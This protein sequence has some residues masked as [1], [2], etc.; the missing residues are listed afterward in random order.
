MAQIQRLNPPGMQ[1]PGNRY[2]H[3]IKAGN[4]VFIAGQTSV[5]ADGNIV[6]EGDITAQ[7]HQVYANLKTAVESVGGVVSD[8]VKTTTYLVDREHLPGIRS[9]RGE[10]FGTTLPTSTLLIV[11][12]LARPELLIEVEAIAILDN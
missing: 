7:T 9:A 4:L 6:G 1:D 12:G 11:A 5:D 8:I 10:F 3:V 2:T